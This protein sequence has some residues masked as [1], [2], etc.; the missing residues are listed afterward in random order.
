VLQARVGLLASYVGPVS[1]E[2]MTSVARLMP[3][4]ATKLRVLQDD[5]GTR[6]IRVGVAL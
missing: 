5:G 2:N 3:S 4:S 6:Y 1:G